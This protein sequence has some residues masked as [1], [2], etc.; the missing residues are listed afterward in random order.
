M[1]PAQVMKELGLTEHKLRFTSSVAM[2]TTVLHHVFVERMQAQ[3]ERYLVVR[4]CRLKK[5]KLA[6]RN[7]VKFSLC[8]FQT[9]LKFI[10]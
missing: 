2:E 3:L 10:V 4:F 8:L 9:V 7:G 6:I 5:F 1:E